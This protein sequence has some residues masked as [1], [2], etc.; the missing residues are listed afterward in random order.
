MRDR[1][2]F[3]VALLVV[4]C[5]AW[6]Q[7][8]PAGPE[9]QVNTYTTNQQRPP[10]VAVGGNGDFMVVWDSYLQDGSV[11]GIFGQ[12]Y[13][14]SG[15]PLG[16]EFR[17]NTYTTWVQAYPAVAADAQGNFV[18]VWY[19]VDQA[20]PAS[21]I[22]GQRYAS[23][24]TPLGAEFRVNSNTPL[25][26]F[27]PAVAADAA[28][29]F[30][31][32]W[33]GS[34]PG[35]GL[36]V[37]GQR[38]AGSGTA[39]GPEFRVNTATIGDQEF[40]SVAS[41]SAGNFVV[42]WQR[43]SQ[44][45]FAQRYATSGDP[46]GAQIDVVTNCPTCSNYSPAVAEDSPGNFVIV[47]SSSNPFGSS[48]VGQRFSSSGAPLGVPFLVNTRHTVWWAKTGANNPAVAADASGNFIVAWTGFGQDGFLGRR[49]RSAVRELGGPDRSGVP[50]QHLHDT[51]AEH[52]VRRCPSTRQLRGGLGQPRPRRLQRRD[53]RPAL[54]RD[55]ARR[56]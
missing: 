54:R 27:S 12:R 4:P 7:G 52:A 25:W 45:I 30:V 9:F 17:V 32:V 38:F 39:L 1:L 18:V 46:L 40:P 37:F 44:G 13:S 43:S 42:V 48:I 2:C 35:T 3:F 55:R 23:D 10:S 22:F 8:D 16:P 28:G 15:A 6:P 34:A 36:D 29:N 33:V 51:D 53:L 47:W 31:V 41:D 14:G 50:D 19:S 49:V 20:A 5:A 11:T 24:G 56:G 21:D 26:Q